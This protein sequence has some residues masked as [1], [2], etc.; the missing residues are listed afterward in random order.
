M[1][2]FQNCFEEGSNLA[3]LS[4]NYKIPQSNP[5]G[6]GLADLIDRMITIDFEER[7]NMTEVIMCLSALYSKKA[8]PPRRKKEQNKT[9][10]QGSNPSDKNS[11]NNLSDYDNKQQSKLP[12]HPPNSE[13]TIH[14]S[15]AHTSSTASRTSDDDNASHTRGYFRTNGQGI[16]SKPSTP[17][18][19]LEAKKLNPNSAAARRKAHRNQTQSTNDGFSN[20]STPALSANNPSS[21]NDTDFPTSSSSRNDSIANKFEESFDSNYFSSSNTSSS[22]NRGLSSSLA[23]SQ[24]NSEFFRTMDADPSGGDKSFFPEST[25]NPFPS[26]IQQIKKQS[27]KRNSKGKGAWSS[28][29]LRFLKCFPDATPQE[30]RTTNLSQPQQNNV[31]QPLDGSEK[32]LLMS[33]FNSTEPINDTFDDFQLFPAAIEETK[34]Q[35]VPVPVNDPNDF[36]EFGFQKTSPDF[37]DVNNDRGYQC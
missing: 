28:K 5:Y 15:R 1:A 10:E 36:D 7:A 37:P 12:S 19:P 6:E 20:L 13:S 17:K 24:N 34:S 35:Q 3:I 31:K 21:T 27:S 26:S 16:I 11:N 4:K 33:S 2:F 22:E 8:L 18:K 30:P 32:P 9:P 14:S 25:E 29:A 23:S